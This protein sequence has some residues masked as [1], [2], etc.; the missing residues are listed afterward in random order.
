[1]LSNQFYNMN[2]HYCVVGP[3]DSLY[4][5]LEIQ[6]SRLISHLFQLYSNSN[7]NLKLIVIVAHSSGSFVADEFFQQLYNQITQAINSGNSTAAEIGLKLSQKIVYYNLDG[8]ITPTNRNNVYLTRLFSKIYFVWAAKTYDTILIRSM[9]L[10][11]IN[12]FQKS[13]FLSNLRMQIQ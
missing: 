3:K 7:N 4:T 8:A 12:I 13:L 11:L 2:N 1:M 10:D 9:V 6:N 5:S